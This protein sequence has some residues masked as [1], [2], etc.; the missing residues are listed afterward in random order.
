MTKGPLLQAA[1]D[2][3]PEDRKK[4]IQARADE[5]IA[6]YRSLQELRATAGL[7]Q[8]K[9]SEALNMSQSNVSRLEK[10]SD[11]LLSTLQRYVAAV[12]GKLNLTVELPDKPPIPLTGLS[13]LIEPSSSPSETQP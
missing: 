9:V 11:M 8:S 13:D 4:A 12:G 7:T 5:R 6:A 2:E 3:L 10:G 1:W